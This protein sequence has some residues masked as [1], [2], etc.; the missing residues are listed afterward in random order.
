M[1]GPWLAHWTATE[2]L[3]V[4]ELACY[5]GALFTMALCLWSVQVQAAAPPRDDGVDVWNAWALMNCTVRQQVGRRETNTLDREVL[6]SSRW[7]WLQLGSLLVERAVMAR[8]PSRRL[9]VCIGCTADL[10]MPI[11]IRAQPL[12]A[13]RLGSDP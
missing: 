10:G 13:L 6:A 8:E 2:S 5:R 11:I 7:P 1:A 12:K 4:I 9:P 3:C